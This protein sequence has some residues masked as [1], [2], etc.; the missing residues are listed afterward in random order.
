MNAR[1]DDFDTAEFADAP[2]SDRPVD[3]V[4]I[5]SFADAVLRYAT[6]GVTISLRVFE[7]GQSNA[8]VRAHRFEDLAGLV[9]AAAMMAQDAADHPTATVF[10]PPIAGLAAPEGQE[11]KAREHDAAEAYAVRVDCDKDP[12]AARRR[13]E[14]LLGPATVVVESGGEWIDPKTGEVQP[15]LHLYWRTTEPAT[16]ADLARLKEACR[17]AALLVD[18]DPTAASAVHPMR[19]PGS[20]HRK[21]APKLAT[22]VSLHPDVE[23]ELG[24]ALERLQEA[25]GDDPA[26][27]A[28]GRDKAS[29]AAA[30][31][32]ELVANILAGRSLHDSIT[33]LAAKW[34]GS[35]MYPGAAVSTLRALMEQAPADQRDWRWHSRYGGIPR[36]VSTAEAKF[37]KAAP[38]DA[39]AGRARRRRSSRPDVP[40]Q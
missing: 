26:A 22:I 16:G 35:G 27:E 2:P 1:A 31:V 21:G 33:R 36:A 20:W 30:D 29:E 39:S 4:A 8:W 32:A 7:E 3:R 37:G 10:C 17:L 34:V 13:L 12:N 23:I 9:S 14:A 19:W 11:N 40:R 5:A 38:D 18:G 6:P 24:D 25:V 15:K 28:G